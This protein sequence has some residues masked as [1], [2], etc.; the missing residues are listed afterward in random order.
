MPFQ[1]ST[2][3]FFHFFLFFSFYKMMIKS[4]QDKLWSCNSCWTTNRYVLEFPENSNDDDSPSSAFCRASFRWKSFFINC[5]GTS[6]PVATRETAE[7]VSTALRQTVDTT[8]TSANWELNFFTRKKLLKIAL[9]NRAHKKLISLHIET[10]RSFVVLLKRQVIVWQLW[11][12]MICHLIS[13]WLWFSSRL[14][15]FSLLERNSETFGDSVRQSILS[16]TIQFPSKT[17]DKVFSF[18]FSVVCQT[19]HRLIINSYFMPR[20]SSRLISHE[21]LSRERQRRKSFF[22]FCVWRRPGGRCWQI[23]FFKIW[24]SYTLAFE[25]FNKNQF[26][27]VRLFSPEIPTVF[28]LGENDFIL[29]NLNFSSLPPPG[30]APTSHSSNH[31]WREIESCLVKNNKNTFSC[32]R[33]ERATTTIRLKYSRYSRHLMLCFASSHFIISRSCCV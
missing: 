30:G 33:S 26:P 10:F 6:S 17:I 5:R 22:L 2:N 3:D 4:W 25:N 23:I 7:S 28:Q 14:N 13:F 24:K 16:N 19:P 27:I 18:L 21:K 29:I 1:P 15:L 8:T 9:R 11:H 31:R 32:T 12:S 20:A